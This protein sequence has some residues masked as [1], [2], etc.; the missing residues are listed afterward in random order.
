MAASPL[1]APD[2]PLRYLARDDAGQAKVSY[3]AP[4]D[5]DADVIEASNL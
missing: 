2:L 5:G 1:A 3:H 4:R